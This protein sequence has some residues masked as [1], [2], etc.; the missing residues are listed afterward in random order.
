MSYYI[1]SYNI[2][3]YYIIS[4]NIMSY[5]IMSYNIMS[6]YNGLKREHG[7]NYYAF[8]VKCYLSFPVVWFGSA[9]YTPHHT[10]KIAFFFLSN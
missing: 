10:K 2:M 3:S 9:N 8:L 5:Y 1:I 6:Y 7:D 4:Y